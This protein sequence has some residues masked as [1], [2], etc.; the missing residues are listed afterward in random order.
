[1]LFQRK[2]AHIVKTKKKIHWLT[3]LVFFVSIGVSAGAWF[4]LQD[5][6]AKHQKTERVIVPAHDIPSNTV[7]TSDDL[8]YRTILMGAREP[9]TVRRPDEVVGKVALSMLYK[10]EQIRL[11]RLSTPLETTRQ[12]VTVN[13]DPV[14]VNAVKPGDIVDVYWVQGENLPGALLAVDAR[15]VGVSNSEGYPLKPKGIQQVAQ[16]AQ[17]HTAAMVKLLVKP[18]EVPQV[19]RGAIGKKIVLVRKMRETGGSAPHAVDTQNVQSGASELKDVRAE[20]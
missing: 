20:E 1:M 7:I 17:K 2:E 18:E 15:V 9:N 14:R 8:A 10:D 12:E 16:Q 3:I 4:Y 11:E 6:M 5:Y 13:V 19:V